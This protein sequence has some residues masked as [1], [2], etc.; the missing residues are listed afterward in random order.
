MVCPVRYVGGG[1]DERIEINVELPLGGRVPGPV[2]E[3]DLLDDEDQAGDRAGD[4]PSGHPQA[5]LHQGGGQQL[6]P[7]PHHLRACSR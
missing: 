7:H 1:G 5:D 4:V 6:P 2:G 3:D